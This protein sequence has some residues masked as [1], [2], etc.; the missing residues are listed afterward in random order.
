MIS[1][2]IR[3]YTRTNN[4]GKSLLRLADNEEKRTLKKLAMTATTITYAV[5]ISL[6][7]FI[8]WLLYATSQIQPH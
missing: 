1:R 2:K 5:G 8:G 7:G 4:P 6:G 3:K